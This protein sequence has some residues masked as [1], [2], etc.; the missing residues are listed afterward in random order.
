MLGLSPEQRGVLE[1]VAAELGQEADVRQVLG[2]FVSRVG[3]A[4]Y[5]LAHPEESRAHRAW[6]FPR[7]NDHTHVFANINRH[8]NDRGDEAFSTHLAIVQDGELRDDLQYADTYR[9]WGGFVLQ[10]IQPHLLEAPDW[11]HDDDQ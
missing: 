3:H 6:H 11:G 9:Q 2:A 4:E 8:T 7:D 10:A 5:Q 1:E